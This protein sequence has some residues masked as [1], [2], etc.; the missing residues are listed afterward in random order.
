MCPGPTAV[1]SGGTPEDENL[2]AAI[3]ARY[4]DAGSQAATGIEIVTSSGRRLVEVVACDP[5]C[6]RR[7]MI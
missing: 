7:L 2:A 1:L 6:A 5:D 4:S 3:V